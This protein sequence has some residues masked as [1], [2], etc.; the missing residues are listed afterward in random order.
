[1]P[2]K[3]FPLFWL[4]FLL[5]LSFLNSILSFIYF[6]FYMYVQPGLCITSIQNP[7]RPEEGTKSFRILNY[8]QLLAVMSVLGVLLL[9]RDTM[10]PATLIKKYI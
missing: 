10:T 6:L 7:R 9:Q 5:K 3:Y 1:M 8:R 2:P 4:K